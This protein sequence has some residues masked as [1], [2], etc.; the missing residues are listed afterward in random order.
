MATSEKIPGVYIVEEDAFPNSVVE[1]ATA[2]PAFI[3]YTEK[4]ARGAVPIAAVP[5]R[6]TSLSEYT[7]YFGGPPA[8]L[9]DSADGVAFVSA[10][11]RFRLYDALRMFFSNGGGPC[12]ITSIGGYGSGPPAVAA[13]TDA[14]WETLAKEQEPTIY[15]APDAVSLDL[16]G[17]KTVTER[18]MRECQTLQ[19]R[20]ALLDLPGGAG[21]DLQSAIQ[22]FWD[23]IDLG[24]QP[25]YGAIYAPWLN[26]NLRSSTD[27]TY[28]QLK[29]DARAALSDKIKQELPTSGDTAANAAISELADKLSSGPAN[30]QDAIGTDQALRNVSAVYRTW[31]DGLLEAVNVVPPAGAMAGVWT[32]TDNNVG[33][34]QAPANTGIVSVISPTVTISDADQGDMNVPLNGKAVN[35]IRSFPGRGVLVWGARTLDGNSQDFR[36]INVRRTLIMLEQS[37]AFAAQAYVFAPN[38]A[39]TWTAVQSMISNF[40]NNQWKAGALAGSTPEQAYSVDVGLGSTM[41]GNDILDGYMRV[42]VRVAITHPAEFIVITFQQKMQTS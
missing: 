2:V 1:V 17:Y 28:L 41:T 6:I 31:M 8:E 40:L 35:A 29:T 24:D 42:T 12:W 19:N 9:F 4:A 5:T 23:E 30:P 3:G 15:V 36:Y 20:V 38:D 25:S 32:R 37:I 16:S 18:M 26:T 22:T 39:G 21:Q 14:I 34:F 11:P 27:V 10:A 7:S 13:Y 33:V